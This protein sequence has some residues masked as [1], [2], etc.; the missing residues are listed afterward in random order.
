MPAIKGKNSL[1]TGTDGMVVVVVVDV[2]GG[3]GR[4]WFC[5]Y[6]CCCQINDAFERSK[7]MTTV[8]QVTAW[9][10][11]AI[12]THPNG[13][14]LNIETGEI[15]THGIAV[16]GFH[17]PNKSPNWLHYPSNYVVPFEALFD[18]IEQAW[19]EITNSGYV[20]GWEN[21]DGITLDIVGLYD[22][23]I[24]T[25]GIVEATA[26]LDASRNEQEAVGWLCPSFANGYKEVKVNW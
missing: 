8:K 17:Y 6:C 13:F 9:V 11:D 5:W 23:I 22:C 21:G 2:A 25:D 20:G 3:V 18:Q 10:M 14:T 7:I 16:G 24:C 4:V 19:D 26:F 1:S 12:N 15:V